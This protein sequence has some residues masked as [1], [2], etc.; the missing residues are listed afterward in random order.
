MDENNNTGSVDWP[1]LAK[2]NPDDLHGETLIPADE[3]VAGV[4]SG[5]GRLG[6]EINSGLGKQYQAASRPLLPY[7]PVKADLGIL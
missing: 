4:K 1:R 6:D 3:F 5:Y 7:R 2:L